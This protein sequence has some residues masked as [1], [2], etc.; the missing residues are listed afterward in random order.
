VRHAANRLY[1]RRPDHG[2]HERLNNFGFDQPGT[3][4]P[5]DVNNDLRIRNIGDSVE[6]SFLDGVEAEENAC[7]DGRKDQKPEADNVPND[8]DDHTLRSGHG[9]IRQ[10]QLVFG[11]DEEASKGDHLIAFL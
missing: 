8:G 5:L 4:R 9:L 2:A 10:L 6:R 3:S 7:A 1:I 11:I